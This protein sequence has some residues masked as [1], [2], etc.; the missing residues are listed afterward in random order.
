MNWM[1]IIFN[2][3]V[4]IFLT[5]IVR[6]RCI[7]I[8]D[9]VLWYRLFLGYLASYFLLPFAVRPQTSFKQLSCLSSKQH[10][11][12]MT[13]GTFSL[14][15]RNRLIFASSIYYISRNVYFSITT[16]SLQW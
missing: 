7:L 6:L 5:F 11:M 4:R 2:V 13:G 15:L 10:R 1:D 3:Y 12:K 8:P 9:N 16:L 14:C